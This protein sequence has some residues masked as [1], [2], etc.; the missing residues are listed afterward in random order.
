MEKHP[1]TIVVVGMAD[2]G[3]AA[4]ELASSLGHDVIGLDTRTDIAPIAGVT[5][6]LGPHDRSTLLGADQIV[7]SPGV[8]MAQAD[9]VAARDAGVPMVGELGYAW[10]H[11]SVPVVAIGGISTD[12]AGFGIGAL[13]DS[14]RIAARARDAYAGK[15]VP[16]GVVS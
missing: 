10:S 11:L 13:L 1:Q 12:A 8:P 15:P 9:L 3:R 5:L 2:S 7:V 4:A 14:D 16:R 6:Q